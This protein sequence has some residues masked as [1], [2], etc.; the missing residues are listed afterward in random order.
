MKL[1]ISFTTLFLTFTV[2]VFSQDTKTKK[3][4]LH[5]FMEDYME[6]A[7]KDYK[8]GK[9][10]DLEKYLKLNKGFAP[11]DYKEEW[12]KITNEALTSGKLLSSCKSCHTEFKKLYK[13][14]YKKRLIEVPEL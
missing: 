12:E 9:K 4:T 11:E 8:K 14:N 10:E 5:D 1:I 2:L 7:E 3:M 6:Q 13:K